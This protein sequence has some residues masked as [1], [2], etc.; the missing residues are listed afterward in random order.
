MLVITSRLVVLPGTEA[1]VAEAV[2]ALVVPSRSEPGCITYFAHRS[3]DH[4]GTFLFYEQ[5]ADQDAFELHQ[6]TPHFERL[7]SGI[8]GPCVDERQRELYELIE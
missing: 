2:R 5:W 6:R 7:V 3:L 8:V 1:S 4:P